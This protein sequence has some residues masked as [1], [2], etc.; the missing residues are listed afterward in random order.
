[1]GDMQG[2][3]SL[4]APDTFLDMHRTT[5]AV[6]NLAVLIPDN[7]DTPLQQQG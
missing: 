7:S 1:M 6:S 4:F 2:Q 5:V 3:N